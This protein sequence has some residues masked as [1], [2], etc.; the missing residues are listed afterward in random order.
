[1]YHSNNPG[2]FLNL[3]AAGA[4]SITGVGAYAGR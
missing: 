4:L 1:M 2:E 3:A